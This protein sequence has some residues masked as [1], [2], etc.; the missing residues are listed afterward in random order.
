MLEMAD[1]RPGDVV[2]DLGCGDGRIVRR[3]AQEYEATGVGF[4]LSIAVFYWAR[5]LNWWHATSDRVTLLCADFWQADRAQS[6]VV[7]AFL[8]PRLLDKLRDKA[9]EEMRPGSRI[10]TFRWE[11][12]GWGPTKRSFVAAG[13]TRES[14]SK[15]T[16][17]YLYVAP[18]K[19]RGCQ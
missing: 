5:L 10:V 14:G 3:A 4:E 15:L 9:V 11:M 8:L 6:D 7:V 19:K 12:P 18:F 16:P 17:V 1:V 13:F 2:F